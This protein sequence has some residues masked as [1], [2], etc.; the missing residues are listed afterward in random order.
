MANNVTIKDGGGSSIVTKTTDTASVHTPHS[1][2][3]AVIPGTGATSLGK[4]RDSA[5]GSTDTGVAMLGVHRASPDSLASAAGDYDVPQ[6]DSKGAQ[7]VHPVLGTTGGS[8]PYKLISAATTNA[9]SVKAAA[10]TLG[11]IVAV[12]NHASN[13]AYLKI[14]NK[15]SAPTVGTDVPVLVL[16][17]A[18]DGGGVAFPVPQGGI[19]FSSGIAFAITG[20]MADSDTSAVAASQVAVNLV[21]Q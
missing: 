21:Y 14:Y 20:G 2:V 19:N 13:I 5:I 3:D 4:A 18:T 15:S 10:G 7:W 6:L 9:T 17:L 1:N 12:N 11:A 8:T 16:P